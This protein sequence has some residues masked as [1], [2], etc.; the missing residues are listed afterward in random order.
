[1]KSKGFTL[2][3]LLVVVAIIG[4]LATVVLASLGS[5]RTRARDSKIK[6]ILNQFRVQAELQYNQNYNDVCD[7]TSTSGIMYR[8]AYEVANRTGHFMACGDQN[9]YYYLSTS[10]SFI[11]LPMQRSNAVPNDSNFWFAE[12]RLNDG[13]WYCVDS[14]GF[15]GVLTSNSA[16]TTQDRTCGT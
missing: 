7:A 10:G 12:V 3:E 5:A 4:I 8:E 14:S 16:A 13:T 2:I 9:E 11:N 6:A 1:M 15:I